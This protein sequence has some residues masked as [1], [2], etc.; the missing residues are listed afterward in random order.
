MKKWFLLTAAHVIILSNVHAET[1]NAGPIGNNAHAQQICPGVCSAKNLQWNGQW[2]TTVPGSM[3]VCDCVPQAAQAT[4][5]VAQTTPSPPAPQEAAPAAQPAP[6][7]PAPQA[8]AP[9]ASL[10]KEDASRKLMHIFTAAFSQAE[11]FLGAKEQIHAQLDRIKTLLEE[12]ADVNYEPPNQGYNDKS[13]ERG[14]P[15]LLAILADDIDLVKLFLEKGGDVRLAIPPRQYMLPR[16]RKVST[17]GGSPLG[18]ARSQ[19][20]KD[21]LISKG[22]TQ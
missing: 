21:F 3:S 10:N 12:G 16:G 20:M 7:P 15:F 8:T 4:A 14:T 22:A 18:Y 1:I 19:A 9:A 2:V 11:S 17:P 5:P 13:A 6:T